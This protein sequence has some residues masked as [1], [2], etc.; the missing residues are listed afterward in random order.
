MKAGETEK[1]FHAR[2]R[3]MNN[4]DLSFGGGSRICLG[5]HLGLLQVYKVVATLA[6]RYDVELVDPGREWKVIN[7]FFARQ[8]G[9]EVKLRKRV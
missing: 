4:A 5:M 8:E 6:V 1:N 7:S 3:E 9:L 2:L